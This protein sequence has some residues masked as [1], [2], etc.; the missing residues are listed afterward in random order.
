MRILAAVLR[1]DP[2]GLRRAPPRRHAPTVA[3]SRSRV[4]PPACIPAPGIRPPAPCAVRDRSRPV[5]I[6]PPIRPPSIAA[7][8]VDATWP[9]P[10]RRCGRRRRPPWR[11]TPRRVVQPDNGQQCGDERH[12][13]LHAM[14]PVF[15]QLP[16]HR[17]SRRGHSVHICPKFGRGRRLRD[18][19]T[20]RNITHRRSMSTGSAKAMPSEASQSTTPSTRP[21]RSVPAPAC[22]HIR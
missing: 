11:R 16:R 15:D 10:G 6:D 18:Q 9:P 20:C 14:S 2:V 1:A 12:A 17:G 19:S 5:P 3:L 8:I 21:G 13:N 7:M 4:W 22:R